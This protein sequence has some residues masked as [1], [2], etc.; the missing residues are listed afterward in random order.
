LLD[1]PVTGVRATEDDSLSLRLL[2]DQEQDGF[3]AA[4]GPSNRDHVTDEIQFYL[5]F[6][7]CQ[8]LRAF[9]SWCNCIQV[10]AG[11]E[12]GSSGR[13]PGFSGLARRSVAEEGD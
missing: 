7:H 13:W 4:A 10:G 11:F 5:S 1:E 9:L 12:E 8:G 2:P 6:G 3:I